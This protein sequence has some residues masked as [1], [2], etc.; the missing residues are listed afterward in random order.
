VLV[1]LGGLA[2]SR[3]V[4]GCFSL[5]ALSA[6]GLWIGLN[7][8]HYAPTDL[9]YSDLPAGAWLAVAGGLV[10]LLSAF[11]LRRRAGGRHAPQGAQSATT[12]RRETAR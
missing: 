5:V 3:A 6:A 8:S 11:L 9:P 2:A 7:A 1:L 12:R 10:G 4:T